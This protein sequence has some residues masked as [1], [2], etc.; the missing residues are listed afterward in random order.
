VRQ[1]LLAAGL[2]EEAGELDER[3][4]AS[5]ADHCLNQVESAIAEGDVQEALHR[6]GALARGLRAGQEKSPVVAG[7]CRAI[8]LLRRQVEVTIM[9]EEG[10]SRDG[11]PHP[12]ISPLSQRAGRT[13]GHMAI[14]DGRAPY[15]PTLSEAEQRVEPPAE[16]PDTDQGEQGRGAD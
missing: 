13:L 6:L 4:F 7:F 1:A 15:A 2:A 12:G 8:L 10:A 16:G 11:K 14:H 9:L 5:W 3:F